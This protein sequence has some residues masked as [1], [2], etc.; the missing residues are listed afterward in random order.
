MAYQAVIAAARSKEVPKMRKGA[1]FFSVFL[2]LAGISQ[3]AAQAAFSLEAAPGVR[4]PVGESTALFTTGAAT[5]IAG[6]YLPFPW[7]G[8]LCC[9]CQ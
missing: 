5:T 1:V 2:V 9:R 7:L 6:Y 8:G 3:T 4:F